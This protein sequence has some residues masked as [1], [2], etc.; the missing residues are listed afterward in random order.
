MNEERA[1]AVKKH[2]ENLRKVMR[3][4]HPDGVAELGKHVDPDGMMSSGRR[5]AKRKTKS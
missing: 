5:P 1:V 4:Y 2:I 3:F